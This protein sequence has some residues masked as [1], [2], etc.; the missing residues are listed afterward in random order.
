MDPTK[1]GVMQNNNNGVL[2][3]EIVSQL[4]R[5]LHDDTECPKVWL[6]KAQL[7]QLG[8]H[9]PQKPTDQ[10]IAGYT[11]TTKHTSD[12]VCQPEAPTT[13]QTDV[14]ATS[15]LVYVYPVLFGQTWYQ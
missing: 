11:Y 3:T 14:P 10:S 5:S 12:A 15:K 6:S 7:A 13:G 1:L 4:I 8:K 9:R 2:T